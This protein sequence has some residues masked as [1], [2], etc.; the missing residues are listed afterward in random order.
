[1]TTASERTGSRPLEP[2]C[3]GGQGANLHTVLT[4]RNSAA[5]SHRSPQFS[6]RLFATPLHL[7]AGR[8]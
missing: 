7:G 5:P 8:S 3:E 1:M 2:R 6:E 4:L